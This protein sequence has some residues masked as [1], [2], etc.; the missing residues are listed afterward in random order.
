MKE[1]IFKATHIVKQFGP[2]IALNDVDIA[3]YPG[4]IRGFIGENGSGKST[5]SAIMT[6]IYEATSGYMEYHGKEWKPAS[7]VDALAGGIGIIVQEN[8]TIGNI[9]VAE[10]IYLG[11][12]SNFSGEHFFEDKKVENFSPL[13]D[14]SLQEFD[15]LVASYHEQLSGLS[16]KASKKAAL[17]EMI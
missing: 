6:G 17:R 7:M 15:A 11:E 4:E 9:S 3:I 12:L 8:G 14:L 13:F 1:P 16:D 10:N 2:T 5:M